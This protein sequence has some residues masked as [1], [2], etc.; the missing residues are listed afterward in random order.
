VGGF[1]GR[2][3]II[4]G[5]TK[6]IGLAIA[7]LLHKEG[8][9]VRVLARDP[10]AGAALEAEL[11]G[12]R[13]LQADVS[14]RDDVERAVGEVWRMDGRIDFLVNNA[15]LTRDGL[16]LR[17]NET[18]WDKVLD[19]DLKGAYHCMQSCL[20][21]MLKGRSG[22]IVSIGSV[23]GETGNVGQANY[24]A[25]KA[26]LIGLTRSVAKE[27]GGR[28]IRVNVVSPG[29]ISTDMTSGLTDVVRTSY[30]A[31]IPLARA[32]QTEEVAQVVTFLLS[33]RASYIT[34]QVVGVNGGLFP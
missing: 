13:F 11:A 24:A 12:S 27:V 3:A 18:D 26:G 15:G 28:G 33:E 23:V 32:G 10:E 7:R 8:C 4:T 5:G 25:A 29:F 9:R 34:G 22:A 19:V 17:M 20:R 14:Q 31:R 30:L 2:T 21:Y 6:G 16:A 1:D